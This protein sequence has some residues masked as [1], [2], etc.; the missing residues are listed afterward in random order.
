[1]NV[2]QRTK[3]MFGHFRLN[4]KILSSSNG[5][6]LAKNGYRFVILR[7]YLCFQHF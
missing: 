1:M 2:L 4:R 3:K 7:K 6:K 5:C